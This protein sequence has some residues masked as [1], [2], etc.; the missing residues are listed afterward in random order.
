MRLGYSINSRQPG[1]LDP[2]EAASSLLDRART[3]NEAGYDYVQAGDHHT[4]G[5]DHYFQ[6]VPTLARITAVVDRVAPLY[7]LPLHHPLLVAEHCGTLAAFADE[8]EFWCAL[9]YTQS[10]FEAFDVPMAERVPRFEE[11]LDIL[12]TL[13]A[14]D[15]VT[16]D[17]E[18]YSL[19]DVSA[20]P[21][22]FPSRICIGGGAEP[23]VRRAGRMGDAWVASPAESPEAM[24]TKIGWFEDAGGGEVVARRDALVL[25]DGDRAN[26]LATELLES[27]YRGWDQDDAE[28]WILVGDA[29]DVAEALAS[30]E[31]LGV[32]DVT[33]RPMRNDRAEE[34]LRSVARARDLV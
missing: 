33:V 13:M 31:A 32:D 17:G 1:N 10:S 28:N 15:P 34:T 14:G 6:N 12:T 9:G 8:F 29:D 24:E 20:S 3:A 2:H 25:E 21:A 7:L 16:I 4:V 5:D 27:G 11:S 26:E 19:T 18:F 23:A 22:A 30:L